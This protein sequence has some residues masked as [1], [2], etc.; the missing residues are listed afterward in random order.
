MDLKSN[1]P[2][3]LLKNGLLSSFPSLKTDESCEVL[4]VGGGIT[5][6]LIAHRCME[7]GY[8]TVLIDRREVCN[9][10]TAATTSMLQYEIDTPLYRLKEMI[11]EDGAVAAYKA[12]AAAITH[13]EQLVEQVSSQSGFKTKASLYYA[14]RK[15]DAGWL[16]QE[17]E[18]RSSAGFAVDWLT[19]HEIAAEH[20]LHHAYGGIMSGQGGSMDAFR[21]SHELL[22]YNMQ[23]GLRIY[24]RTQLGSVTDGRGVSTAFTACG[25]RI[26]AKKIIYCVGYESTKMIPE[27]FVNLKSTY[28][29][30]S[31]IDKELC[32]SFSDILVWN[33]SDPYLYMRTT[34]DGRMLIGG[35]DEDFYSASKRDRLLARKAR[36]LRN[37]F[38][39]VRPGIPFCTDFIWAGTFGET[40]D[41][42]P[43]I[44]THPAFK[45]AFFVL[46]FGGNGITFS[47]TGMEM[48]AAWL[49]GRKHPLAQWFRFGR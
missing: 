28:A 15:K 9:G 21:L 17:M 24:D 8:D 23:K 20:G 42:L 16:Q 1:E 39:R 41:G 12:C 46:G 14:A 36:A 6:S 38:G 48:A 25:H 49:E 30:V 29:I 47:V 26:K 35:G 10:S 13:L 3:W 31:E 37:A 22:A 32:S 19:E 34:D 18:A 44:G 5:G 7:E 11:G 4:I 2:F 45:N 27:H 40:K 33:T 43:Y